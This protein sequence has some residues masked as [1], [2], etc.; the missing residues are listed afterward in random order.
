MAQRGVRQRSGVEVG[1]SYVHW[2]RLSHYYL[3]IGLIGKRGVDAGAGGRRMAHAEI[4]GAGAAAFP[5][6]EFFSDHAERAI[7]IDITNN[8]QHGVRRGVLSLVKCLELFDSYFVSIA[9][10]IG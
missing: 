8:R 2:G 10:L 4:Y 6:A 1:G 9:N 5:V 3:D 7:R